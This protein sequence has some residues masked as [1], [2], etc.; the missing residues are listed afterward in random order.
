MNMGIAKLLDEADS[1]QEQRRLI[2]AIEKLELARQ[3]TKIQDRRAF[4][5]YNLGIIYWAR[6]GN[7]V[8]AR[9]EFL[10]AASQFDVHGYGQNPNLRLCHTGA[11]ENAMLCALSYEEF[12]ALAER[13]RA[14]APE[15]LILAGLLP[16]VRET[17]EC[18]EPWSHMLFDIAFPYYNRNDPKLDA[19]RYGEA[20]ST[21]H[22]MLTNR[23][24][25][26]LTR[27]DWRMAIQE[28]CALAMRMEPDCVKARGGDADVHS[29]EEFLPILT[30]ALPLVDE[31]LEAQSGDEELRKI[32]AD[33]ETLIRLARQRWEHVSSGQSQVSLQHVPSVQGRPPLGCLVSMLAGIG[34]LV[35]LGWHYRAKIP[36]PEIGHTTKLIF[37]VAGVIVL[38]VTILASFANAGRRL[39]RDQVCAGC[40]RPFQKVRSPA[41]MDMPGVV[42][43]TSAMVSGSEGIGRECPACGRTYCSRCEDATLRCVCG[44]HP[45]RMVRLVYQNGRR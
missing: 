11:L 29:P 20:K 38:A 33:M 14:L 12:E 5:T 45:L 8:A 35:W 44:Q 37:L 27:E 2:P 40:G 41:W 15:T 22:L 6:L 31:Y 43:S 39:M 1:L 21:Y 10:A 23:R 28:Y 25:L 3:L 4:A 18:G 30:D 19:G 42:I 34:F 17:R 24:S 7:G 36:H 13:L 9:R 16:A 26:R 32:R